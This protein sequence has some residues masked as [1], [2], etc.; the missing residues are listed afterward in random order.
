MARAARNSRTA[1]GGQ[2]QAVVARAYTSPTLVLL[3]MDW[4][5]TGV[6][7]CPEVLAFVLGSGRPRSSLKVDRSL[8]G[9]PQSW[10]VDPCFL[11]MVTSDPQVR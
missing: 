1:G 3:A 6:S 4:P 5:E 9:L 8:K 11:R 2:S 10:I 7:S